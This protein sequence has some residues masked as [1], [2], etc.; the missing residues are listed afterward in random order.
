MSALSNEE[1]AALTALIGCD[2]SNGLKGVAWVQG[3]KLVKAWSEA[4]KED[5]EKN[6]LEFLGKKY[7]RENFPT[8]FRHEMQHFLH[9]PVWRLH[10]ADGN[11]REARKKFWEGNFA[12]TLSPASGSP[13]IVLEETFQKLTNESLNALR[14]SSN[15]ELFVNL[16]R[17]ARGE[18]LKDI[19]HPQNEDGQDLPYGAV[20]RWEEG[21]EI[22]HISPPD[23]KLYLQYHGIHV[24]QGMPTTPTEFSRLQPQYQA[25]QVESLWDQVRKLKEQPKR[26]PFTLADIERQWIECPWEWNNNVPELKL[27]K[28]TNQVM[29]IIAQFQI[30][31]DDELKVKFGSRNEVNMR[32]LRLLTGGNSYVEQLK[33]HEAKMVNDSRK[34]IYLIQLPVLASMKTKKYNVMIGF[35]KDTGKCLFSPASVCACPAGTCC[36]SHMIQTLLVLRMLQLLWDNV[37]Q[38]RDNNVDNCSWKSDLR[39]ALA[40]VWK[41]MPNNKNSDDR[42]LGSAKLRATN[43]LFDYQGELRNDRKKSHQLI[44]E[45]NAIMMTILKYFPR[46]LR[47][48]TALAIPICLLNEASK[49]QDTLDRQKDDCKLQTKK[50]KNS[51]K[52]ACTTKVANLQKS[53]WPIHE[54]EHFH[55]VRWDKLIRSIS[56]KGKW[57][58][59]SSHSLGP[60]A[61]MACQDELANDFPRSRE[62]QYQADLEYER[63]WTMMVERKIPIETSIGHYLIHTRKTRLARMKSYESEFPKRAGIVRDPTWDQDHVIIHKPRIRQ[64]KKKKP[65]S[66]GKS[67]TFAQR[68]AELRGTWVCEAKG[69][70]IK[71]ETIFVEKASDNLL[72]GTYAK[73]GHTFAIEM[74]SKK[75]KLIPGQLSRR[76]RQRNTFELQQ[77][78]PNQLSWKHTTSGIAVKWTRTSIEPGNRLSRAAKE[79]MFHTVTAMTAKQK[80]QK[81][82]TPRRCCC[83]ERCSAPSALLRYYPTRVPKHRVYSKTKVMPSRKIIR[84]FRNQRVTLYRC[85]LHLEGGLQTTKDEYVNVHHWPKAFWEKY[86]GAGKP[87][88]EFLPIVEAAEL[89]MFDSNRRECNALLVKSPDNHSEQVVMCVPWLSRVEGKAQYDICSNASTTNSTPQRWNNSDVNDLFE[90][91]LEGDFLSIPKAQLIGDQDYGFLSKEFL[92]QN[93]RVCRQ[94]FGFNTRQQMVAWMSVYFP[95]L[96]ET[97]VQVKGTNRNLTPFQQACMTRMYFRTKINISRLAALWRTERSGCGRIIAKWANR[98]GY[99]AKFWCR[100]TFDGDYLKKCQVAGMEDRYGVPI[101]HLA[102]GTVCR[103]EH[104]RASNAMKKCM[105]NNKIVG[106]GTLALAHCTPTGLILF[107][108]EMYG[109]NAG[110]V[111]LVRIYRSWWDAYPSGFG[112]LVD[113]GFAW[114]TNMF[115]KNGN[116]GIYPDFLTKNSILQSTCHTKQLSCKQVK[117]SA[118]Q[119]KERYVVETTFSRVKSEE[120]ISGVV[121]F[122][123]LKYIDSAYMVGC[124]TANQMRPLKNP[125]SW[126]TIQKDFVLA[127]QLVS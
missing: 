38:L 112:R 97:P 5:D 109:G 4:C 113:K 96:K 67:N 36:C 56:D 68:A 94:L 12:V 42:A 124:A 99:H 77:V 58:K 65:Q 27:P 20:I 33:I 11:H 61:V 19:P 57:A 75:T 98:W 23:L 62:T 10:F 79:K 83:G 73:D 87:L 107:A 15:Q 127:Q 8:E 119:S 123:A 2:Y 29:D 53:V 90:T 35:D 51:N 116:K 85:A 46:P 102:D 111:E 80:R 26:T 120:I 59:T 9:Y 101:S 69:D 122:S 64:P 88:P 28:H 100:L 110:E 84:R 13:H 40:T 70:D 121:K 106:S 16:K 44:V 92:S 24:T 21:W 52:I 18:E 34:E 32:A 17:W 50:K 60:E 71:E 54:A 49:T 3:M 108:T 47:D 117:R 95:K 45:K 1:R 30:P 114:F 81:R 118:M 55:R 103:T 104:P 78:N 25:K 37:H 93:K 89:G 105:W 86:G 14:D 43:P 125:L 126:N 63:A 115:Y 39:D 22:H 7:D 82:K 6:F 48:L 91:E 41:P 31:T 76:K 72:S 74:S 66:L